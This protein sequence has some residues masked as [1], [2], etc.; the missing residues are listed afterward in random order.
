M[1]REDALDA[2]AI[3]FDLDGVLVDTMPAIRA[4]W[5]EWALQRNLAP[6]EVLGSIHM[7]GVELVRRF[8]PEADPRAEIEAVAARQRHLE[9]SVERYPGALEL[10]EALPRDRW[11]VVTSAR[12][13]GALRHLTLA[14]LPQP[15]VL[16]TAEDT[17]RGKPDPAGYRLAAERLDIE[18][19][20][21]VAVE[22]SPG[23]VRAARDAGMF[24]IAV[25]TTHAPSEL[26]DAGAIVP[27]VASLRVS[28]DPGQNL[29]RVR[30]RWEDRIE[31][32]H[33]QA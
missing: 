27:S 12:R 14:G 25:T 19:R 3:V 6:A 23:G 4:A 7:T 20:E 26:V 33:D 18:P 8:A 24:T 17:L 11:A 21:C 29:G 9:T 16:V 5:A 28:L 15:A 22:D 31:D 10:L 32:L 13:A 30:V 2:R 1:A